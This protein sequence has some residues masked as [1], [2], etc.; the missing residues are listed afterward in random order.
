MIA[1]FTTPMMA[2]LDRYLTL[3]NAAG[4]ARGGAASPSG[5]T[6]SAELVEEVTS[7]WAEIL[8]NARPSELINLPDLPVLGSPNLTPSVGAVHQYRRAA[9]PLPPCVM[10]G[11]PA[12]ASK[13][14]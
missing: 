14:P 6:A 2:R 10:S 7:V 13:T 1:G 9:R 11:R 5:A 3:R 4:P 8:L 12:G